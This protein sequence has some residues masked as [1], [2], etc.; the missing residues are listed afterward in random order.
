MKRLQFILFCL[1]FVSACSVSDDVETDKDAVTTDKEQSNDTNLADNDPDEIVSIDDEVYDFD[2][3]DESDIISDVDEI[4][5]VDSDNIDEVSDEDLTGRNILIEQIYFAGMNMGEAILIIGPDGTSVLIDVANDSHSSQIAEAIMRRTGKKE[6]DWVIITHY[7]NDHIGG[8]DNL[9]GSSAKERINIKKGI[10]LRGMLDI[11]SDMPGVEDFN[12]FCTLIS[13]E[14][15]AYVVNLCSGTQMS[16]GGGSGGPWPAQNCDGLLK[17]NLSITDD[18]SL[19]FTSFIDLGYGAKIFFTHANGWVSTNGGSTSAEKNGITIGWGNTDEENARSLG[20]VLKWGNFRY[21][22]AGDTQGRDIKIEKFIADNSSKILIHG[23]DP[24]VSSTGG[25]AMHL[26]H[27]G[28]ASSTSAEWIDWLFPNDGKSRNAIV[29]TTG[30]Y[31]TSPAQ[32]VLDALGPRLG[33]GLVWA[34]AK[35]WTSGTSPKLFVANAA[36]TVQVENGGNNYKIVTGIEPNTF[37]SEVFT[38]TGD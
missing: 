35:A 25:D 5:T 21:S 16:C 26:S 36:V 30:I 8:F 20:G 13:G 23:T 4:E 24:L 38:S 2:I 28:L 11:G 18:D 12:E 17:G 37:S 9:F 22:F 32:S 6:I 14:L 10:V 15:S 19:E 34:N 3:I 33:T 7:H 31:V 1:I 27:H 29:G